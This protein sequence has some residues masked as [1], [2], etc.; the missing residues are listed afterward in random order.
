[1]SSSEQ[2]VR[3]MVRSGKVTAAE[4]ERLLDALAPKRAAWTMLF[5]PFDRLSTSASIT[6]AV[7]V[8]LAGIVVAWLGMRF[9]GALDLHQASMPRS[10]TVSLL[11]TANS[12]LVTSA[13]FWIAGLIAARQGRWRDF[14]VSVA[15]ARAPL[16]FSGAILY[17]I[18][19]PPEEIMALLTK[20][21]PP[22]GLLV[23]SL[24]TLPLVIWFIVLL[25]AAFKTSSGM[26]GL[27]VGVTFTVALFA[28][29]ILT[30][31]LL[32]ISQDWRF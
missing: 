3:D 30:K 15:A 20:G 13:V 4:G 16:V 28:S 7:S 22:I 27:R 23:G 25:F 29:E 9:D 1:M 21:P 14:V 31:V 17:A 18:M 8:T 10:I 26:K 32:Y 6:V 2:Q 5:N 11:D 19:P 24:L 12:I